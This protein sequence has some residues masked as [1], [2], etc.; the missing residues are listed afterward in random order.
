[1]ISVYQFFATSCAN[2]S[3]VCLSPLPGSS[4]SLTTGSELQLILSI[5]FGVIGGIAALVVIIS[6]IA[7]INSAGD[8]KRVNQAKNGILYSIVGLVVAVSA[9]AIVALVL[10]KLK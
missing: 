7:Y 6:G 5:I 4:S 1:M 10:G 2:S 3:T 8:P 9:E